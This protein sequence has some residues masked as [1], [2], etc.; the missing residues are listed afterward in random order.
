MQMIMIG[1]TGNN[2]KNETACLV[3]GSP[4]FIAGGAYDR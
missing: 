2:C 3:V 1:V 4:Y